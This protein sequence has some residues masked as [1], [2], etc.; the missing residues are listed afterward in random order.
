MS[1]QPP[2]FGHVQEDADSFFE[3]IQGDPT[4][5]PVPAVPAQDE[6]SAKVSDI[7]QHCTRREALQRPSIASVRSRIKLIDTHLAGSDNV[8]DNLASLL[9]K[10]ANDM[11][12]LVR[13]RTANLQQR[14]QELEEERT[15][16]EKLM[17]DLKAAK[18]AA[19]AAAASK[20]AFL[21]NMSHGKL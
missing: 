10:Y 18:E 21:A 8:V 12:M 4:L 13:R 19:E 2:W 16:A 6:Y 14:T 9:E 5:V 15:R 20:Q 11:E 1:R 3:R 17:V 7:A